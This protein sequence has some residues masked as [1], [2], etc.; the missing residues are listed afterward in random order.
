MKI[1]SVNFFG[2]VKLFEE[3][4]LKNLFHRMAKTKITNVN[5]QYS[6]IIQIRNLDAYI[7]SQ[8]TYINT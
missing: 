2:W 5:T 6:K 3:A 8:G 1:F 7:N 4:V